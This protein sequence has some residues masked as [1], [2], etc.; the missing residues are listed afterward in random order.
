MPDHGIAPIG[1][2]TLSNLPVFILENFTSRRETRAHAKVTHLNIENG[3]LYETTKKYRTSKVSEHFTAGDF[4]KAGT[5]TYD[6]AR[7]HRDLVYELEKIR[8]FFN[9]AVNITTGY[10]ETYEDWDEL[11]PIEENYAAGLAARIGIRGIPG[12]Q[13]A[14]FAIFIGER[15]TS[16]SVGENDIILAVN[17]T[18]PIIT[19][20]IGE[21]R[22]NKS[23]SRVTRELIVDPLQDYFDFFIGER[24][25]LLAKLDEQYVNLRTELMK[26]TP[27][28]FLGF[29][30]SKAVADKILSEQQLMILDL[31]QNHLSAEWIINLLFYS[32]YFNLHRTY[33]K[34][35]DYYGGMAK[36]GVSPEYLAVQEIGNI[37]CPGLKAFRTRLNK[38]GTAIY[39]CATNRDAIEIPIRVNSGKADEEVLRYLNE[40]VKETTKG[41]KQI[42]RA[43][44]KPVLGANRKENHP[45]VPKPDR[46][47]YDIT[48]RYELKG[49]NY[50]ADIGETLVINQTG[51]HFEGYHSFLLR[52]PKNNEN[53]DLRK[54]YY[55]IHGR[56]EGDHF[57]GAYFE[58]FPGHI[59]TIISKDPRTLRVEFTF[60][61]PEPYSVLEFEKTS[62]RSTHLS[63]DISDSSCPNLIRFHEW[64]PLL[65][66]QIANLEKCFSGR[67][68][69]NLDQPLNAYYDATDVRR[70]EEHA[71]KIDD[72][73]KKAV[74]DPNSGVHPS[75]NVL[76]AHYISSLLAKDPWVPDGQTRKLTRYDYLRTMVEEQQIR[77][78]QDK[79]FTIRQFL[80]LPDLSAERTQ[81]RF[82]YNVSIE[83]K[84]ASLKAGF[85]GGAYWGTLTI[86][87]TAGDGRWKLD[88]DRKKNEVKFFV[89]TFGLA[90]GWGGNFVVKGKTE[91]AD[92]VEW[93]PEHFSGWGKLVRG[94]LTASV[95]VVKAGGDGFFIICDRRVGTFRV[96]F[97]DTEW[98][99]QKKALKPQ[100]EGE[101][102]L[103]PIYIGDADE[104]TVAAIVA[105]AIP[106]DYS[107]KYGLKRAIFHGHDSALLTD[108]ARELLRIMCA[109]ELP[110]LEQDDV[111]ITI[112]GYTDRMGTDKHNRDLSTY[113]TKNVKQAI[114]DIMGQKLRITDDKIKE[115]PLGETR[116]AAEGDFDTKENPK[117]R[118]VTVL[119]NGR[120]TL[121]L[122]GAFA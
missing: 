106:K 65:Q 2:I 43:Q 63:I 67:G 36:P 101:L 86:E 88:K 75:D 117:Y 53:P 45:D 50:E 14:K 118:G 48:G 51:I 81:K 1:P 30:R 3:E 54:L 11:E 103:F 89:L 22:R 92:A 21:E 40:L 110:V 107:L 7:I 104:K 34:L 64:T 71:K 70:G 52:P 78:N 61:K 79:V 105:T 66:R 10:H 18:N 37:L 15:D 32:D 44:T 113:R 47:K 91:F 27:H 4:A 39:P 58:Q 102:S 59:I 97:L 74:N 73:F 20:H 38:H 33:L 99:F 93:L 56:Q 26:E 82:T 23:V 24:R 119:I 94:S 120:V 69:K 57:T 87:K 115:E 77:K 122:D 9:K 28:I 17:Q 121:K 90:A 116:A 31:Y 35:R 68:L 111:E 62:S 5:K 42:P 108:D 16:I 112:Q 83:L 6:Y 80:N 25:S 114:R 46:P 49:K 13:L 60:G 29:R 100:L 109:S 96:E 55:R 84:G 8:T 85:G 95:S 76:A 12:P 72:L 98:K 19:S 41:F